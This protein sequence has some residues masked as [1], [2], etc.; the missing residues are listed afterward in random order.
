MA[1][2]GYFICIIS[3]S[4]MHH[5]DKIQIKMKKLKIQLIRYI[6]EP[7]FGQQKHKQKWSM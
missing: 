4:H 7:M 3:P 2:N 5:N 6:T 1:T